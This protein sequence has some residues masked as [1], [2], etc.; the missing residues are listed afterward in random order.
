MLEKYNLSPKCYRGETNRGTPEKCSIL[1][2]IPNLIPEV[3]PPKN[4]QLIM[5]HILTNSAL[6]FIHNRIS[7]LI[8]QDPLLRQ[9][10]E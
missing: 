8:I 9:G 4:H 6:F 7:L 2:W 1:N 5:I 3:R 10:V